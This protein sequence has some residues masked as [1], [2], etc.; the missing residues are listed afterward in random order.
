MH[1]LLGVCLSGW[2]VIKNYWKFDRVETNE[3]SREER[4][5]DSEM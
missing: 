2:N 4:K 5:Q 1:E 3:K